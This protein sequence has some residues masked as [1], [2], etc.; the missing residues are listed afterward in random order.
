GAALHD[1][2]HPAE[3]VGAPLHEPRAESGTRRADGGEDDLEAHGV[4]SFRYR[5]RKL[6]SCE[7]AL[8]ASNVTSTEPPANARHPAAPTETP[9]THALAWPSLSTS[10]P[11]TAPSAAVTMVSPAALGVTV[12]APST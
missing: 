7:E 9:E 5:T 6:T 4:G 1:L 11:A 2:G 3:E 12:S 8:V 10:G